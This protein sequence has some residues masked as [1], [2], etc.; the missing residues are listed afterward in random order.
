MKWLLSLIIAICQ[1]SFLIAQ[2]TY[3]AYDGFSYG[4]TLPLQNLS[5]GTGW[6]TPWQVQNNNSTVPGYQSG[7]GG[8]QVYSTLTTIGNH[9]TGGYQYLTS[10]RRLNTSPQG[11]FAN[12]IAENSD[13]IGSETGDTLW[14]SVL[15]NKLTNDAQE[16]GVDLHDN[17]IAWCSGC[18]NQHIAVGYFGANSNVN[19]ERRWTLRLANT[20]YPTDSIVTINEAALLVLRIVFISGNTQVALFVNP[21]PGYN[22]PG[23][24]AS[25][26][27]LGA[28]AAIRSAAVYLGNNAG[29]AAIDELRFAESY[30]CVAPN[31]NVPVNLPPT[32]VIVASPIQ[33]QRPLSVNFDATTS[34]DPEA[35]PLTYEWNFGDGSPVINAPTPSHVYSDLGQLTVTLTATDADG[36]EH[37]AYQ[38]ITVLDENGHFPCQT[39]VSCVQ[40]ASCLQNSGILVVNTQ[41]TTF[42]LRNAMNMQMPVTNTNQFQN[43][44]AGNYTLVVNGV[45]NACYDSMSLQITVDSSSCTG[46]QPSVCAMDI[47]TNMSGFSDWSVER[48]LK[49]LLKHVRSEILT[50]EDNCFCWNSN[51]INEIALDPQGYPLFAPQPTSA[52]ST[53]LRYVVSADGGNFRRD[54]SYLLLYDGAG[55]ISFGGAV[56]ITSNAPGRIAFTALDNGNINFNIEAS[57]AANHIRNIRIV[58]PQHEFTDLYQDGFYEVFKDKISPFSTLRFMDWGNTNG[59]TNVEWANRA[60]EDYFTYAGE[61]GIPYEV[62]IRL[63]NELDKNVWICV[64]HMA[65]SAYV[66]NMAQLF[67]DS[68][69]D[70]LN[71]YL[72][73][74]N[75]VWNWIF[76]QAQYNNNN[77]PGNLNYGRAMAEKAGKVFSIW[78]S[79]FGDQACRVK[80]VLGI[81]AGFNY[82][83][84]QI[85]SQ[86]PQDAWD[87]GS[88]THYFGLDHGTTGNP[89]LDL[90]GSNATPADIL[91]NALNAWNAFRPA[92]K[93]DYRNIQV[94]GKKVITYEGGQHFVGN[95]FGI[96]YPYQQAM[97]DAQ[98]DQGMYNLYDRMHDSIRLWGCQLA[99]NFSL[100]TVQ[101]S[102]YGS[103]GVMRDIET[104]PPYTTTA[105]KYQAVLDNAP[106]SLCNHLILWQGSQDSLWSNPC[107]WDKTRLP[108]STDH[109]TIPAN[110]THPPQLD[111]N[112]TIRSIALTLNATLELL[113]GFG[114]WILQ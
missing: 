94:F 97:W 53:K 92:V 60:R 48:P 26:Q 102:V 85:L 13:Y 59:N 38:T 14:M 72:E 36:L 35:G 106:D 76:P 95:S 103:W 89:R 99:T 114:L 57:N 77:R 104:Q 2:C 28:N 44:S 96:P 32:A 109:V 16:L 107:N 9:A 81:Q 69:D 42:A 98:N 55:T 79:V 110:T 45:G 58:R 82:L 5:G 22:G 71:I 20:Y 25:Q 83:N 6:Q 75:E 64:P 27:N 10:G 43:L 101:E 39:S 90:L 68:L 66:A 40:M 29:A 8:S 47:G 91:A 12:Y 56:S 15:L 86:L 34:T 21:I 7:S 46:W 88:P 61:K 84:E 51:V 31:G 62:M 24:A 37:T 11:P 108:Q 23:I 52:G 17:N 73:Y 30:P 67:L 70:H 1:Y 4:S 19:G 112:A 78:H 100:A 18:S 63:C 50:Y 41:N 74:S 33:G 105:K 113:T 49:N 3:L 80:R 54:S 93:Q 111:I 87:Y 65:D